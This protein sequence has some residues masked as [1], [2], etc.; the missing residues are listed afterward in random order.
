MRSFDGLG[1]GGGG[2]SIGLIERKGIK[3]EERERVWFNWLS[4]N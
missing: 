1:G 4:T 2:A 3:E